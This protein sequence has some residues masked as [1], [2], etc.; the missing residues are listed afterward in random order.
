MLPIMDM[1]VEQYND[2]LP[3]WNGTSDSGR[4]YDAEQIAY[5]NM[6]RDS[7][8][9]IYYTTQEKRPRIMVWCSG[10]E[11][12]RHLHHLEQIAARGG[13]TYGM[14]QNDGGKASA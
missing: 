6:R 9:T 3:R 4:V 1:T 13:V 5:W 7:D 10:A 8:G 2:A 12:D 11:L 14:A